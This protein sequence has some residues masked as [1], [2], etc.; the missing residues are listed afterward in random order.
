MALGATL[1]HPPLRDPHEAEHPPRCESGGIGHGSPIPVLP[2]TSPNP[3]CPLRTRAEGRIHSQ[4]HHPH[5]TEPPSH[6]HLPICPPTPKHLLQLSLRGDKP[7]PG[8]KW[9]DPQCTQLSLGVLGTHGSPA[10]LEEGS[11]STR[12]PLQRACLCSSS[13]LPALP[14]APCQTDIYIL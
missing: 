8:D 13:L 14:R 9:S 3:L 12:T 2:T 11:P 6:P 1:R 5:E 10:G 7:S 4:T